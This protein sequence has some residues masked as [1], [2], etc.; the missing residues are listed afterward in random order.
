LLHHATNAVGAELTALSVRSSA[1]PL[2]SSATTCPGFAPADAAKLFTPFQRL[3]GTAIL[4]GSGIG[5]ATVDRII[6][7]LGERIWF[8]EDLGKGATFYFTPAA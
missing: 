8:E 3:A 4:K 1:K 6:R 5:L 2:V 7:R